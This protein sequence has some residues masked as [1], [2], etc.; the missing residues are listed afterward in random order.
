MTKFAVALREFQARTGGSVSLAERYGASRTAVYEALAG[1][2]LPS[3]D[4]LERIVIAWGAEDEL[5]RWR[6]QRQQTEGDLAAETRL[7]GEVQVKKTPEE[8]RFQDALTNLWEDGGRPSRNAWGEAAGLSPRTVGAYLEGNTLPM[9]GKLTRLIEGLASLCTADADL[10]VWIEQQG[11]TI[12]EEHLHQARLARK[13]AR[14]EARKL[15]RA[16]PGGQPRS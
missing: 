11:A 6:M 10:E 3:N 12:R 7:R 4:T 9:P 13:V 1:K 2:R 8:A 15:A 5:T 16:L 14:D